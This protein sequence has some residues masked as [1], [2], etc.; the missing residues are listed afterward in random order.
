M[1]DDTKSLWK[2]IDWKGKFKG[3]QCK[4]R[5]PELAFQEHMERLLNPDQVESLEYPTSE[6]VS[7]P[8]LDKPFVLS[9]LEKAS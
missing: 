4:D 7:I 3:F 6:Q 8:S 2:G 5:P 1:F 9:K